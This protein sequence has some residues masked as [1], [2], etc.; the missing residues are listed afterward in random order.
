M[1]SSPAEA[2]APQAQGVRVEAD[3]LVVEL[4]D[5]RTVSVPVAWYPRLAHGS[6]SERSDWRLIGGGNGIHWQQLDED[7]AVED[8]LAGRRSGESQSSLEGWLDGRHKP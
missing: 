2:I 5:G 4:L 1:A 6:A 7:I 8:L 3:A